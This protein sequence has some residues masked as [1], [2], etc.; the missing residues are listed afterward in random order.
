MCFE[1]TFF[2]YVTFFSSKMIYPKMSYNFMCKIFRVHEK[3][4]CILKYEIQE[5]KWDYGKFP[6]DIHY[7][8]IVGRYFVE[9]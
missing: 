1:V 8:N 9:I 7:G 5:W 6:K 3:I 2:T 4:V